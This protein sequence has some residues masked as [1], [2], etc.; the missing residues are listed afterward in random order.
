MFNMGVPEYL[1]GKIVLT[2]SYL[3]N[4]MSTRDL[5]FKTPW[6]SLFKVFYHIRIFISLP[7][8]VF[9]CVAFV[10]IHKQNQSKLDLRAEKCVFLDI[11]LDKKGKVL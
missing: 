1:W 2:T 11:L 9:G 3:I 4:R 8:S 10:H 7:L 6:N 5:K